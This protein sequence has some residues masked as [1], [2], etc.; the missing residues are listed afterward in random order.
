MARSLRTLP[1]LLVALSLG[2]S[3]VFADDDDVRAEL[4][5]YKR[6]ISRPALYLRVNA[7]QS[8]AATGDARAL[9]ALIKRYKRPETPKD[10]V[11][12]LVA[13]ICAEHFTEA[14]HDDAW[15]QWLAKE[16]KRED[17]W[18]WYLGQRVRLNTVGPEPLLA[19]IGDVQLDP[20]LRTASLLALARSQREPE[21]LEAI[22]ATLGEGG[23]QIKK[24][25]D[26]LGKV[27]L[28][29]ACAAALG[30]CRSLLGTPE[31]TDAANLVINQLERA[32]LFER[33]PWV[34]ARQLAIALGVDRLYLE[35]G[36][37]RKALMAQEA[38]TVKPAEGATRARPVKLGVG[39]SIP[40]FL[41]IE[42]TGDRV[43][44][45]IDCSD[46]MLKPL[47]PKEVEEIKRRPTT[48][49][50]RY[51]KKDAP[52][53][54]PKEDGT[55]FSKL[56]PWDTIETR[57]DAA[58]EALKLSLKSLGKDMQYVVILFGH[59]AEFLAGQGLAYATEDNLRRTTRALRGLRAKRADA[60]HPH[61]QLR[62]YTNVHGA[63][64]DAFQVTESGQL[65]ADE[66]V[67]E[68]GFLEGISTIF[69]LSDGA[70]SWDD[71]NAVDKNDQDLNSGNPETGKQGE[72]A[73]T[74]NFYGPYT[75]VNHLLRDAIRMN[76]FRNVEIHC[77]GIGEANAALLRVL[78][79]IGQGEFRSIAGP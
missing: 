5:K 18:L 16:Q 54:S 28:V 52:A 42:G 26:A 30:R 10:H 72:K 71:F 57:F 79:Q 55:D 40:R 19:A 17:A 56:L 62:G 4:R 58:R 32:D 53:E 65:D 15:K 14:K 59:D 48:G 29:E 44:F 33:S 35:A 1:L 41:G 49:G 77:I 12:F 34:I 76:L 20:F 27:V 50:K 47:T 75:F 23:P 31:F 38:K 3:G 61:G 73:P 22:K 74:L 36:L 8:L 24:R 43:A 51:E 70:P 9:K 6:T 37:W 2:G 63:L 78:A 21:T 64:R 13:G 25:K 39:R 60:D 11:A 66:H 7:I 69:V 67:A 68:G 45:L 46:S